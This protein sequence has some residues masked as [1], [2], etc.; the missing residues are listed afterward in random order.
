MEYICASTDMQG[1]VTV[2]D[3]FEVSPLLKSI[4]KVTVWL[5]LLTVARNPV[6]GF[7]AN[8]YG[9]RR[10]GKK[11]QIMKLHDTTYFL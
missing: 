4:N 8:L 1:K 7:Q 9:G 2:Q 11:K 6:S 5:G 3:R 10:W